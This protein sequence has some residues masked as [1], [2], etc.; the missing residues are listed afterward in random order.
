MLK[1]IKSGIMEMKPQVEEKVTEFIFKITEGV[2]VC[3]FSTH[4]TCAISSVL[5]QV[6]SHPYSFTLAWQARK[7][8][9][10]SYQELA[11]SFC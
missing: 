11:L 8:S 10:P 9:P 5:L 6:V 1:M 2:T 3:H 7:L 4:N